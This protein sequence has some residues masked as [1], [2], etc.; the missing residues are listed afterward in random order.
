MNNISHHLQSSV[1]I[2]H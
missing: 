1:W 2:F